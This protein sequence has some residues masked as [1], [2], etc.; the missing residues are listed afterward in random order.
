VVR[1]GGRSATPGEA[2]PAEVGVRRPARGVRA[3][4]HPHRQRRR[5]RRAAVPA[6]RR[7]PARQ[8]GTGHD[9]ARPG[10]RPAGG[11]LPGGGTGRAPGRRGRRRACHRGGRHRDRAQLV[12]EQA[13]RGG[14]GGQPAAVLPDLLG[15][16]SGPGAGP[17]RARAAGRGEG[18]D[19]HV[20]LDVRHLPRLG[21]PADP[22]EARPR[23]DGPF[24]AG[25]ARSPPLP[26][27]VV[28][29]P[30]AAR[31]HRAQPRPPRRAATH[32]L[33]RLRR[34]DEHTPRHLGG[35]PVAS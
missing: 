35:H 5:V 31:P 17:R 3:R 11:H 28:A 4:H 25:G 26:R 27:G 1:V 14:G 32:V 16:R 21:Q 12:R 22:G 6:A 20:G 34:V 23:R 33:R 7:R 19:R 2:E 13:G 24:R 30:D 8:A 18:L 29:P 9:G 15:R 10:H